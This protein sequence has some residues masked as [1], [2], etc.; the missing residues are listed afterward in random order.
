MTSR[1]LSRTLGLLAVITL[2]GGV[3]WISA[4]T[5]P[6]ASEITAKEYRHPNLG[7]RNGFIGVDQLNS[8]AGGAEILASLESLAVAP[9]AA[10]L[11]VRSG[12]WGTLMPSA[13]LL[14]GNGAGN[15]IAWRSV[16]E[17]PKSEVEIREAA[18]KAFVGYLGD[19]RAA[20]D[21]D[22]K[23]LTSPGR[24]G[25]HED[26]RLIQIHAPRQID[27]V[28]VKDSYLTAVIR[29]GNLVLLGTNNWADINVS[30]T[31]TIDQQTASAAVTSYLEGLSIGQTWTKDSLV[32]VPI[33]VGNDLNSMDIGSGLSYR[34]AWKIHP[35]FVGDLG[36]W[37]ALVDAHN[38]ELIAFEDTNH[39]ASTREIIG[40]VYPLANDGI[41]DEGA[42]QAGWPMPF[43][44]VTVGG[45]TFP[46]DSGGN[47]AVCVDGTISTSLEGPFLRMVDD[48]GAINESTAGN[49]LDLGTSAGIDCT[50]PAGSASAG[51]THASRSGYYEMGRIIEM[52]QG[53]LPNNQWLRTQLTSNMNINNTCNAFWS[54]SVNFYRSGGGCTNTGEIAGV[55]D[56]EWGHGMDDS[57]VTGFISNPGEGIADVYA[58]LRLNESCIG[59]GFRNGSNCG[60][61]GDSCLSCDGVRDIDWAKR[62]SGLPHDLTSPT[63]IDAMCGSGGGTPCGGSTHC[64]GAV[65]AEAVYDLYNRDLQSSSGMDLSTA[66]EVA[67]RLTFLGAGVVGNWYQCVADFGG[68]NAD[69]GYLNYLA[70]DDD[71]GDL[72][73]GTPNMAAIF[74]AFD[75]HEIACGTPAVVDSGCAGSP[76]TAPVVTPLARD[77]GVQLSWGAVAGAARYQLYRAEGVKGCDY[78]KTFVGETTGT[79]FVDDGLLNGREYYYNVVPM[80]VGE[81]CFGPASSCVTVVPVAGANLAI[82]PPSVGVSLSGGDGDVFFDNCETAT[83]GFDLANVGSGAANNVVLTS[84]RSTS[85]PILDGNITFTPAVVPSLAACGFGSSGFA[86]VGTDMQH[87]DVVEFEVCAS[88]DEMIGYSTCGTVTIS[89][90]ESDLQTFAS[91]TFDFENGLEGWE[92]QE[93]TFGQA[94]AGGGAGAST[95]YVASSAF[96]DGQCDSIHSP[97]VQMSSTTTLSFWNNFDIE[98]Y[99]SGQWWDRANVKLVDP[100]TGEGT[101]VSP[102]GGRLYNTNNDA[103]TACTAGEEGWA[104][105]QQTWA[106]S[107]FSAAALGSA[108]LDGSLIKFD[109]RYGT[110]GGVVGQGFFF[111]EVTMTDVSVQVPDAQFCPNQS[112]IFYDGFESGGVTAWTT[113]VGSF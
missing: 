92:V 90:V 12:R 30:T 94:T 16:D 72:S 4:L 88:S 81:S 43:T 89:S 80:G 54:G 104:D 5:P 106:E 102:D 61:Y 18:W 52:A 95:G 56:H 74:A 20:L 21:I 41:G 45:E 55:Y 78:G 108:G 40:G 77:R 28:P 15:D 91:L 6:K 75:R 57:D 24:V 82:D 58:S 32:V 64:E 47:L 60:G 101:H 69:G 49:P 97:L 67:T 110:D 8:R 35:S 10:Y 109:L 11:D 98:V 63:G 96:L 14:P 3:G 26:G 39:Y 103:A 86:V 73:D 38:G 46:T 70:A 1:S 2:F 22:L 68:C 79:T 53:Q 25:V 51:N 87:N 50:T 37:Q 9:S 112:T 23:Q 27:G 83:V 107:S 17:T 19:N 113:S 100:I 59:R 62:T 34:L 65:Y 48:C 93:G 76:T 7:I 66:R 71:N 36:R 31:P 84:V 105:A 29:H 44:N 85:H 33:G 42:E 111:D 99:S 13:P